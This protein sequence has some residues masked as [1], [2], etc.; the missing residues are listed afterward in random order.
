MPEEFIKYNKE[1]NKSFSNVFLVLIM[2]TSILFVSSLI[3]N[4]QI[5]KTEN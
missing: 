3:T 4:K 1:H 2:V 5:K